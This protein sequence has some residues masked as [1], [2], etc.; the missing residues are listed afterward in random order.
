MATRFEVLMNK[1]AEVSGITETAGAMAQKSLAENPNPYP[2]FQEYNWQN[3]AAVARTGEVARYLESLGEPQMPDIGRSTVNFWQVPSAL[4]KDKR[5]MRW[6]I[7]DWAYPHNKPGGHLDYFFL[8]IRMNIPESKL[9]N[10]HK[11]S[12]SIVYYG[13][14]KEISAGC[15]VKAAGIAT[16]AIVRAYA[17]DEITLPEAIDMYDKLVE[18][19]VMEEVGNGMGNTPIAD[20][21][22]AYVLG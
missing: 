10:L 3:I 5:W 22:E 1:V 20:Q 9:V 17:S 2:Q 4:D 18:Q 13:V 14:G 7:R 8:T 19:L 11:I 21:Y 15:H 6:E 12:G 16:L